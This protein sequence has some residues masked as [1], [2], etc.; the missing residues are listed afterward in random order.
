VEALRVVGR[1]GSYNFLEKRL[2][3]GGKVVRQNA[4]WRDTIS[5]WIGR[6][7]RKCTA[8]IFRS[9]SPGKAAQWLVRSIRES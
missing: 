8:R 2:A 3:G 5:T 6:I 9:D 4:H 1:G 7:H